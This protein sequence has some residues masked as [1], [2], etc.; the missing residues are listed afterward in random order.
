MNWKL[1]KTKSHVDGGSSSLQN[2]KGLDDGRRHAI[3]GLVNA[4]VLEGSLRLGAPVLVARD[5]DLAKGVGLGSCSLGHVSCGAVNASAGQDSAETERKTSLLK[6][7]S[8]HGQR[9]LDGD[10]VAPGCVLVGGGR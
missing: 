10:K 7:K 9:V 1:T 6:L 3:L 2:T 8:V 4:E 5:L